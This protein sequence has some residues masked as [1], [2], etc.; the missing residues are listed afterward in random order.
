[1]DPNVPVNG[2]YVYPT[3]VE[4]VLDLGFDQLYFHTAGPGQEQFLQGYGK[5]V[6]PMLKENARQ[7]VL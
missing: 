2:N 5:D 6:L 3:R 1:L 4:E 7:P